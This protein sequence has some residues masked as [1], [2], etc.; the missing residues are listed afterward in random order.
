[1]KTRTSKLL[2]VEQASGLLGLASRQIR[3]WGRL[4][5]G[6]FPS[7]KRSAPAGFGRDARTKRRDACST[8]QSDQS[9]MMCGSLLFFA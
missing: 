2:K 8:P 1:M 6:D 5:T 3:A 4:D 7:D 9:G